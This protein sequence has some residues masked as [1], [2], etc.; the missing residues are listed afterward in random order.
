MF[1]QIAWKMLKLFLCLK[2]AVKLNYIKLQA[3]I[4]AIVSVQSN[5]KTNLL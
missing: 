2:L 3:N 4:T 1:F 5:V